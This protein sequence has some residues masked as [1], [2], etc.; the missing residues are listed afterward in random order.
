[1]PAVLLH[2]M[3]QPL[4]YATS[5]SRWLFL[6]P[7]WHASMEQLPDGL[8]DRVFNGRWLETMTQS[9]LGGQTEAVG[10][11]CNRPPAEA[12]NVFVRGFGS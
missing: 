4:T 1:M 9:L 6:S 3:Q 8:P 2:R 11:R 10:C 7:G 5:R 12:R